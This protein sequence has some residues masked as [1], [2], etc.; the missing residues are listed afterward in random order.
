MIVVAGVDGSEQTHRVV[1]AALEFAAGSDVHLVYVSNGNI[2]PYAIPAGVM[3]DY[4]SIQ[5]SQEEAVWLKVG[6]V[7][8]N[9][10]S[11]TLEGPPA[12]MLVDYA[13]NVKADMIVVGSR[14]RGALG[15]LLLGSVGHGVVHTADRNVLIVK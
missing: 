2:Y 15:S 1:A 9:V 4:A 7:P 6:E 14:G 10:Q 13:K 5:K 8:G 3:L 11:V 12:K